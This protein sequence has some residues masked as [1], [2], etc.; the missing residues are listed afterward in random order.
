M[1][2]DEIFT[3]IDEIDGLKPLLSKLYSYREEKDNWWCKLEYNHNSVKLEVEERG[4]TAQAA[5]SQAFAKF[6]LI[7]NV[8]LGRGWDVPM[9]EHQAEEAR[10]VPDDELPF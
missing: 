6:S 10:S 1:T 2:T 7:A 5:L 8:G 4:P 9:L 3:R